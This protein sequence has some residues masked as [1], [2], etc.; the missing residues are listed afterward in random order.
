MEYMNAVGWMLIHSLWQLTVIGVL[1]AVGRLLI[2]WSCSKSNSR[3]ANRIYIWSVVCLI[4]MLAAPIATFTIGNVGAKP[5]GVSVVQIDDS[6]DQLLT[7]SKSTLNDFSNEFL[8]LDTQETVSSIAGIEP[9]DSYQTKSTTDAVIVWVVVSWMIG[10][11]LF[12]FRLIL[13]VRRSNYLAT[14]KCPELPESFLQIANRV[15]DLIGVSAV[16]FASSVLVEVPTVVGYFRPV[17]LLPGSALTGLSTRQLEQILA[18]ELAH[19]RRHD[20]LIN[21]IQIIIETVLF[22]HPAVWWLSHQIRCERENCCDD[23]AISYFG[24]SKSYVEA[25]LS[26]EQTRGVAPPALASNGG[27]LVRRARRLLGQPEKDLSF[28]GLAAALIAVLYFAVGI[29]LFANVKESVA[30]DH[31]VGDSSSLVFVDHSVEKTNVSTAQTQTLEDESDRKVLAVVNGNPIYE[32]EIVDACMR[33]YGADTLRGMVTI[34]LV[35]AEGKKQ[36]VTVSLADIESE[37]ENRAKKFGMTPQRFIDLICSKRHLSP[38]LFKS[39]FVGLELLVNRLAKANGKEEVSRFLGDLKSAA[40][41]IKVFEDAKLAKQMPGVAAIVNDREISMQALRETCVSRFGK[42]VLKSHV[43]KAILEQALEESKLRV[44]QADLDA[45]IAKLARRENFIS[46][47]AEGEAPDLKKWL[48]FVT[49]GDQSKVDS[50]IQD[51]V[52]PSVALSKLSASEI[53]ISDDDL[54]NAYVSYYGERVEVRA[55]VL[56]DQRTAVKVYAMA[57]ATPTD[58]NFGDLAEAYSIEPQ[59]KNNRGIIPPVA[60]YRGRPELEKAAL[61]LAQGELSSIIQVDK[62]WIILKCIGRIKATAGF[63]EVNAELRELVFE[64]KLRLAMETKFRAL[65]EAAK[66]DIKSNPWVQEKQSGDANKVAK[67]KKAEYR[68]SANDVLGVMIEGVLGNFDK[69]PSVQ[70]AVDGSNLPP[71]IGFPIPVREDGTIS[72]PLVKPIPVRGLTIPEVTKLITKTYK[73]GDNPIV[74]SSSRMVV[75]LIRSRLKPVPAQPKKH[76]L[77]PKKLGPKIRNADEKGRVDLHSPLDGVVKR[78]NVKNGEVVHRGQVLAELEN[79][80]LSF[81]VEETKKELASANQL[82][83]ISHEKL[84]EIG[85]PA[86]DESEESKRTRENRKLLMKTLSEFQTRRTSLEKQMDLLNAQFSALI[87]VAPIDGKILEA[88]PLFRAPVAKGRR[89]FRIKSLDYESGKNRD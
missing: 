4:A 54:H 2:V 9:T 17:I 81:K 72:L 64:E 82:I 25:L 62:E 34:N 61:D 31:E 21:V 32:E 3:I 73:E 71:S 5:V 58:Q 50:Y 66:V 20:Y 15:A 44:L 27:S 43:N 83:R 28:G 41:I 48:D 57:M 88:A 80:D 76:E 52:W 11:V 16:K 89:L 68:V 8:V 23:I 22:F 39:E 29:G 19:I 26:L 87:I 55:I 38:G 45:E 37:I 12:S 59:T 77:G 40:R 7:S 75:T 35:R 42:K 74:G 69:A 1:F 24:D 36:Q 10:I 13:G 30:K 65:T 51:E 56:G 78:L 53:S 85:E 47:D 46:L 67:S 6:S 14:P 84:L 86:G 33:R 49:H 18:H 60:Q 79:H 63:D 70:I